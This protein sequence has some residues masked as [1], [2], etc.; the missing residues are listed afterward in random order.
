VNGTAQDEITTYVDAVRDALAD[1]PADVRQELLDDLPEH[2]GEVLAEADGSLIERLGAPQAY[3]AEL[4]AA[5]GLLG[6]VPARPRPLPLA[7]VRVVAG[8]RLRAADVR[9]GPVLGYPRASDFL[10]LLRPAWWVLR[11]Y[12]AAMVLARLLDDSGQPIGLLPRIGGS[13]VVALLLLAVGV[14]G[15]IWLGR[16]T[17]PLA[18][19]PRYALHCGTVL[20]VLVGLAGFA[21]ADSSTRG[22]SYRDV[23]Y[24]N[25]NPYAGISDVYA[26]DGQGHLLTGVRL[27]DQS[28]QPIRLGNPWCGE[29]AP[30]PD[31]RDLTYPY[32]PQNAPF[33]IPSDAPPPTPPPTPTAPATAP[34]TPVPSSSVGSPS[35]TVR[36][37][38]SGVPTPLTSG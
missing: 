15:S 22:S 9:L 7:Q 5:A 36:S 35:P 33:R 37:T 10:G 3:A 16:R 13:E 11:G 24:D 12:L 34:A 4:R 2:L 28:G 26:Y 23:Q 31:M 21:D 6:S 38:A 27:F 29:D 17:A 25:N 8:E 18:P 19:W 14:V 20:L 30:T 1:L 32:C